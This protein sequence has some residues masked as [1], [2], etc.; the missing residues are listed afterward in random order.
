MAFQQC[1]TVDLT[2]ELYH[3]ADPLLLLYCLAAQDIL[4]RIHAGLTASN[5]CPAIKSNPQA[6]SDAISF[7][8]T[9]AYDQGS[10]A[11]SS[12]AQVMAAA[13]LVAAMTTENACFDELFEAI[14][15]AI[16]NGGKGG[17]K[18]EYI[19]GKAL[20]II[21]ARGPV[22]DGFHVLSRATA[23][24]ICRGVASAPACARAW[25]QAV[26]IDVTN[27]CAVL[28][29]AYIIARAM[30]ANGKAIS[31]VEAQ[32]WEKPLGFCNAQASTIAEGGVVH[33]DSASSGQSPNQGLPSAGNF[34]CN[35]TT[36][37]EHLW[38]SAANLCKAEQ[39][40]NIELI[41]S[42]LVSDCR[43]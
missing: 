39:L 25:N 1:A 15:Q 12:Y 31:K 34:S 3:H 6:A 27:G 26:N 23:V 22:S 30:C 20:A 8:A 16:I 14:N 40:K 29:E 38:Q 2:S 43:L 42:I 11:Q 13:V 9:A 5:L 17:Y 4:G 37:I 33:N 7:G 41:L 36:C 35:S 24:V 10:Q 32:G 19:I 18:V 21:V 28:K